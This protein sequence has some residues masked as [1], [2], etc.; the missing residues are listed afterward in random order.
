MI[1]RKIDKNGFAQ[2]KSI[3]NVFP[4]QEKIVLIIVDN[5]NVWK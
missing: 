2:N 5:I 1:Q 3:K 4:I